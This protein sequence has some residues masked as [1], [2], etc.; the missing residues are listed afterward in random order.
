MLLPANCDLDVTIEHGHSVFN[1][2]VSSLERG[3]SGAHIFLLVL[4]LAHVSLPPPPPLPPCGLHH[5]AFHA[6]N[7]PETQLQTLGETL[8][9]EEFFRE[10]I[11]HPVGKATY[12][13]NAS[14]T[15]ECHQNDLSVVDPSLL[16]YEQRQRLPETSFWNISI[17]YNELGTVQSIPCSENSRTKNARGGT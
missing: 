5:P 16:M 17:S 15:A 1:P 4:T 14:P 10:G 7:A 3:F 12:R 9:Q 6:N 2:H 8:L 11:S 13:S